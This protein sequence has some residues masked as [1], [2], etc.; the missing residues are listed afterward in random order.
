MTVQQVAKVLYMLNINYKSD[1][2]TSAEEMERR[3]QLWAAEF[4]DED[5]RLVELAVKKHMGTSEFYPSIASIRKILERLKTE[6]QLL[7]N[8]DGHL[9]PLHIGDKVWVARDIVAEAQERPL[10][11]EEEDFMEAIWNDVSA[12]EA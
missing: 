9:V 12:N 3:V 6:D 7:K 4:K 11:P 2:K 10:T 1:S 5:A 8:K